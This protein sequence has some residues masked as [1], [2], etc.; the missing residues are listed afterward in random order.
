MKKW[1]IS[2]LMIVSIATLKAQTNV[3]F[4]TTL[5]DFKVEIRDDI[6]P[7]TG[8]NFLDLVNAEFYDGVIFHRVIQN[9]VIQGGDP[10]GTGSGGPGYTIDDEFHPLM[11]NIKKTIS[12]ANS[13]PNSGGSQFF[14][15]MVDNTFL[16]YDQMPLSSKHPVFGIVSANFSVVEAIADVPV[17]GSDRPL[18]DVVMDSIRVTD[19]L[20]TSIHIDKRMT[21]PIE[22]FPNPIIENSVINIT[23]DK[24][25]RTEIQLHDS[26]GKIVSTLN[27][28]LVQGENQFSI[29][30]LFGK[31]Y[32]TGIYY[33]CVI[34]DDHIQT[35]RVSI[36]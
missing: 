27:V 9:F 25:V 35:V 6:V 11:S 20:N 23:S 3:V 13:G 31:A 24:G 2:F 17:D 33:L 32:S 10:T 5:G 16:D 1:T 7:I 29:S 18:I 4:Y 34:A 12:M 21:Y 36:L 26:F 30:S 22:V 8:G 14:F 19:E 28:D 15:N